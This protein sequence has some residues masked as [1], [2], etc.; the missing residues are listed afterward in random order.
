MKNSQALLCAFLIALVAGAAP[1]VAADA[2]STGVKTETFDSDPNW[3]G[4]NNHVVPK[5]YPVV[6]Q[7]F[8]YSNTHFAGAAGRNG[9]SDHPRRRAG[10]VWQ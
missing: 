6:V 3:E 4:F 2:P 10:V 1:T 9:R 7:D 5:V 8:G